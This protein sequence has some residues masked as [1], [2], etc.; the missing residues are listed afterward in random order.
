[1][2]IKKDLSIG[3]ISVFKDTVECLFG[4][5]EEMYRTVVQ[6]ED[7]THIVNFTSKNNGEWGYYINGRVAEIA[8]LLR[9]YNLKN[10]VDLGSGSGIL[11]LLLKYLG[12]SVKGIEKED[13]LIKISHLLYVETQK[14]DLLELKDT[15]IKSFDCIYMYEPIRDESLCVKF[16]EKLE[17]ATH[18]GQYIFYCQAGYTKAC[19][20]KKFNSFKLLEEDSGILIYQ[21]L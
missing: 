12:F 6:I 13:K 5:V 14:R 15:D 11:L 20:D 21:R 17:Q 4:A 3:E 16:V 18:K 2:N 1:M 8:L 7:P 10:I 19:L 9:K